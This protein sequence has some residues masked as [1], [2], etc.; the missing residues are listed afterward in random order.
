MTVSEWAN[1]NR[2]LD[3]K[4]SPLP[5]PWRTY[6]TP[7]LREPMDMFRTRSV[8]KITLCFGTQ[9]GKSESLLNMIGYAIDQDPGSMLVVYPTDELAKSI[10]KNRLTPMVLHSECLSRKWDS[11]ASEILE[12]QFLGMVIALVGANSPSKLASR[13]VR[14]VFY[15]ETDKFPSYSGNE[16]SPTELAGER[17][18][19]WSNRKEVEASSPTYSDGHIWKNFLSA[20]S[21]KQFF[22]P[23][24]T[25]GEMQ[26]LK[27][28]GI[29]WP[30]KLN[31]PANKKERAT[32]VLMES[33]YVCEFC[34]SKIHDMN[35]SLMLLQGEWRN[36]EKG[37]DGK[38]V[39]AQTQVSARP[40][41]VAYNLSSLYSPWVTFGQ[42]A[43]KFLT[44]K[45]DQP[46]FMNFVN[47]WLAEPWEAQAASLS[48]DLVMEKQ[49]DHQRGEVPR[50]AQMLTCGVD[51]QI[52]HFWYVV[53]AWGPHMTSWLVDFGTLETWG[54]LD[55]ALDRPYK[56]QNG[57]DLLIHLAF[58]DSGDR[59]D[60][61]YQY[62]ATRP[63][64]AFPCKG[65]SIRLTRAPFTESKV[66]RDGYGNM[67]LFIVDGHYYKNFI[68]GRLQ[69][70]TDEPGAFMV[71]KEEEGDASGGGWLRQYAEQLCSE[72]LVKEEDKKGQVKEIWKPVASH[73][74]NH[75]LDAEVYAI[76]AAERAGVRY[77]RDE[78][79]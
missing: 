25:C 54:E 35:K 4:T 56:T 29:K 71:Y 49:A 1:E 22:V 44:T 10:S 18:K 31:D 13:P 30:E 41:H 73:A 19:N 20:D 57:D 42:V 40:R 50:E 75:L 11:D 48:S 15:D 12:L 26:T 66:D 2:I 70:K 28:S 6:R 58:I 5:G 23:C 52:D 55:E 72:R 16:G 46:R 62:C 67:R 27:L 61:V 77:L 33:W 32:R 14:Y 79:E 8:D 9:L 68:A 39:K 60:E 7:Y 38:I 3:S 65:S 36:V 59:T 37:E 45:E 51:V 21:R 47:G 63:D 78:T 64:V 17:V 34:G 76:A 53:R 24:P 74:A 69:K 43:N